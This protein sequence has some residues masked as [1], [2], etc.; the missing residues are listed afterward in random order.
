LLSAK[1]VPPGQSGQIE[2]NIDTKAAS[3]P[4]TKTVAVTSNDPR[5]RQ[6]M[7]T[8]SGIVQPE[9]EMAEHSVFLGNVPKGREIARELLITIPADRQT[10]IISAEST[11]PAIDARINPVPESNGKQVKVLVVLKPV[12]QPGYHNGII[13]VKTSSPRTPE[14][15]ILVRAIV[16]GS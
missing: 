8:I 5:Q 16:D 7:L 15:R 6:V 1:Q 12:A 3:G 14:L 2:V 10:K 9:F 11:D 13:T 4:I